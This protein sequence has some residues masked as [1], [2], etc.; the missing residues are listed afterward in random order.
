MANKFIKSFN[1]GWEDNYF[2]LPFISAEQNGMVL[3]VV[4]GVWAPAELFPTPTG[5]SFTIDG[6]KFYFDPGMYW[7]DWLISD[8]NTIGAEEEEVAFIPGMYQILSPDGHV[9]RHSSDSNLVESTDVI[10]EN[11]AYMWAY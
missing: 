9:L 3:K 8:Y 10:I 5:P 7:H 1:F 11:E 2:P 4:D 6:Q